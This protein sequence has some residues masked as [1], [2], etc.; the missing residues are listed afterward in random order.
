MSKIKVTPVLPDNR[1]YYYLFDWCEHSQTMVDA[2]GSYSYKECREEASWLSF[3]NRKKIVKIEDHPNTQA[4][5]ELAYVMAE[6]KGKKPKPSNGAEVLAWQKWTTHE[7]DKHL[8]YIL[9][10]FNGEFVVWMFN[11]QDGGCYYGKYSSNTH[12]GLARAV[13]IFDNKAKEHREYPFLSK[14]EKFE[15]EDIV[16]VAEVK[17]V[18]WS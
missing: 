8:Y 1:P 4:G 17:G 7:G 12:S 18:Q 15:R 16:P 5:Y 3:G 10:K 2:F 11:E 9:A 13:R 14:Q 6:S